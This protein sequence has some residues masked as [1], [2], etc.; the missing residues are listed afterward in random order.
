LEAVTLD[1][2]EWVAV[3]RELDATYRDAA[4]PG[5]R[6]R[7]A[8]LLGETPAGWGGQSCTLELEADAAAAVRRIVQRGRGLPPDAGLRPAQDRAV[9][10]AVLVLHEG[11]SAAYRVEHRT[12]GAAFVVARTSAADARQAELSQQAAR[13][14]AAGATGE[15]VL[16]DEATGRDLARR[17]LDPDPVRDDDRTG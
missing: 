5:L 14:A 11:R 8:A 15:V 4:P 1:R 2:D 12:G 9:A 17:R 10:E 16:V 3:A 7:L 13:L 6:G